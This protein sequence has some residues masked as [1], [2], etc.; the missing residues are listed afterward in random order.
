MSAAI[1]MPDTTR[2]RRNATRN[3][4]TPSP[5]PTLDSVMTT[6]TR[7]TRSSARQPKVTTKVEVTPVRNPT[8]RSSRFSDLGL[9]AQGQNGTVISASVAGSISEARSVSG[10]ASIS[11]TIPTITHLP[12]GDHEM[13]P[14]IEIPARSVDLEGRRSVE[15]VNGNTSVKI[16][17]RKRKSE[18]AQV[19]GED[20]T[21]K[22]VKEETN[23]I[24][25]IPTRPVR[26]RK[27]KGGKKPPRRS[28]SNDKSTKPLPI[29][30][31]H[32]SPDLAEPSTST[33][34][35]ERQSTG[36]E[37]K[38]ELGTEVDKTQQNIPNGH[39]IAFIST[40]PNGVIDITPNQPEKKQRTR[41]K[42]FR[43]GEIDPDDQVAVA[44]RDARFKQIDE[45]LESLDKQMELI[46]NDRHPELL[47]FFEAL[48]TKKNKICG[49]LDTRLAA[50]LKDMERMRDEEQNRTRRTF[51]LQSEQ[52]RVRH[53]TIN[54]DK[55]R[56]LQRDK[57]HLDPVKTESHLR[58]EAQWKS[59]LL[60]SSAQPTIPIRVNNELRQ[61]RNI[62]LKPTGARG[63]DLED[64]LKALGLFRTQSTE[65]ERESSTSTKL[66]IN[67]TPFNLS[68]TNRYETPPTP[69]PY[70][71]PRTQIREAYP[72]YP[73]RQSG[74]Y[75]GQE[76]LGHMLPPPIPIGATQWLP[77]TTTSDPRSSS[78]TNH[79][80]RP[81]LTSQ[82]GKIDD[83]RPPLNAAHA[84][85][86]NTNPSD[87]RPLPMNEP[88]QPLTTNHDPRPPSAFTDDT[89]PPSSLS[90]NPQP[91]LTSNQDSRPSHTSIQEPIFP[92]RTESYFPSLSRLKTHPYDHVT[93][94]SDVKPQW[95]VESK[96][97]RPWTSKQDR[98]SSNQWNAS[99][100]TQEKNSTQMESKDKSLYVKSLEEREKFQNPQNAREKLVEKDKPLQ[101]TEE[102]RVRQSTDEKEK[103]QNVSGKNMVPGGPGGLGGF[104]GWGPPGW[105][106]GREL[107]SVG[108]GAGTALPGLGAGR[109]AFGL[110]GPL[111]R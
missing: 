111:S 38:S 36:A 107:G 62:E 50:N 20:K 7:S 39:T 42:Y 87:S 92:R 60:S 3:R 19:D 70:P 77:T 12:N 37:M 69:Q 4:L 44:A 102:N 71:P 95:T 88:R 14:S 47:I 91:P 54:R 29:S 5:V 64:D 53:D 51:S 18:E 17:I 1:P 72:V 73:S 83:H 32:T 35:E 30:T 49:C 75:S 85:Q 28:I 109:W 61:R 26:G 78:V 103:S 25:A 13:S 55:R 74:S 67:S 24:E 105:R 2:P 45:A 22:K 99:Q 90:T 68:P 9:A 82:H 98:G 10:S 56:L 11:P 27:S 57:D 93:F 81:L 40:E 89:R 46:L 96:E 106:D 79:D 43:K 110:G 86:P 48:D 6:S 80:S 15:P 59:G 97:G 76:R 108:N 31:T 21:I 41:K 34:S 63:K 16:I 100:H 52:I 58:R 84:L 101:G 8:R 104:G 94:S 33:L 65:R 23:D 66:L